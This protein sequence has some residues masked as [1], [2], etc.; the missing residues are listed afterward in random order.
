MK[1]TKRL[2]AGVAAGMMAFA[3]VGADAK[4][5]LN[6]VNKMIADECARRGIVIVDYHIHLRGGMTTEKCVVREN[7][8]V[9][10]SSAMDN[11]GRDWETSRNDQLVQFAAKA[12][13]ANPKMPVGIQVNDRDWFEQIDAATRAKFDYI[14]A[15]TMIFGD[16]PDW[17]K[18]CLWNPQRIDDAEK[19]M[20]AY[21]E[22]N[23]RILGEPISILANPTYLP[24][25][26]AGDYDKLWTEARM[27]R[28]IAKAVERGIAIE[29][30]AGSPYPRP[31]FLKLAKEMGANFSFGTN[32]F[33]DKP[34]DLTHWL[35]AITW[36]D[37]K[38]DDIWTP[39]CLKR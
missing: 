8:F 34:K 15:D 20:D 17:K 27:R 14:L 22:H 2:M 19:W 16:N 29:I 39:A 3:A 9:V 35:D 4:Y 12:R 26:I 13:A 18:N 38:G 37:L 30:Q 24:V 7:A 6:D 5:P 23:L 31:K 33:D 10:R 1:Y 36:L 21:V 32:N 11:H 25:E 28:V